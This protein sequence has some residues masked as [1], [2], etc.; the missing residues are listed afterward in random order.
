MFSFVLPLFL[1]IFQ[2]CYVEREISGCRVSSQV[3]PCTTSAVSQ[4][5]A[6]WGPLDQIVFPAPPPPESPSRQQHHDQTLTV[7]AGASS[8]ISG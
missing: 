4:S 5:F 6:I 7:V 1:S 8:S 2:G 3:E